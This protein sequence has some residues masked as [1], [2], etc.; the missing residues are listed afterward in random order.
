MRRGQSNSGGM[1]KT[2]RRVGVF[3]LAAVMACSL[4]F[5]SLAF[6]SVRVDDTELAQG[7][8]AVGGGT[9]TLADS[10]LDMS[11]VTAG[12]FFTDENLS[13]NFNGGNDIENVNI[14]GSAAVELTFAGE[15]DVEEVHASG[16]SNVTLNANGLNDFEEVEAIGQSN[17]T[18][19]VTGENTFEEIVGRDDANVTIRGTNCQKKDIINLGEDEEDTAISTVRG[20][21]TIDHVTVNLKGKDALVG[22]ASGSL[23]IDT[24][25][26][27]KA[28]GNENALIFAGAAMTVYESVIDVVG[29]LFSQGQM[30]INHSDV[31]AAKP[32][33]EYN[34]APYRVFSATGI[35]LI[36]EKNGEVKEG[37]VD[38]MDV[39]Y[40]D[41]DDNDGEDVDLK[42]DGEPAYYRCKDDAQVKAMPK[43]SDGASPLLLIAAGIASAAAAAYALRRRE[44]QQGAAGR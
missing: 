2:A 17:L 4:C 16:S 3:A 31:K 25:K 5:P 38:G 1:R 22:S 21:L 13:V 26:I 41:T 32:D 19:N 27:G 34:A 14:A 20:K 9:A 39:W 18:V 10:T 36:R 35:D 6:A 24:S 43:T 7:Q 30:T 28:D 23:V 37:T 12:E 29:T 15:N 8:N 44:E 11:G 40:V 42:A 33:S